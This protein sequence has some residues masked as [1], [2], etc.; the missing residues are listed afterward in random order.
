MPCGW[1]GRLLVIDDTKTWDELHRVDPG[2]PQNWWPGAPSYADAAKLMFRVMRQ[3]N[4]LPVLTALSLALLAEVYTTPAESDSAAP[5]RRVRLGYRSSPI[6]DFGIAKG[7]VRVAPQDRLAYQRR[8]D[9]S[10][11]HGQDPD[12][13]YWLYFTTITGEE[14][15][16]DVSMFT[17]NLCLYV[18]TAPY[19]SP[20]EHRVVPRAPVL[21]A[22]RAMRR[23]TPAAA[24]HTERRRVS[25]LRNKKLHKAVEHTRVSLYDCDVN[26]IRKF[27]EGLLERP[28]TDQEEELTGGWIM[29]CCVELAENLKEERWKTYP[30]SP[31]EGVHA[32]PGQMEDLLQDFEMPDLGDHRRRRRRR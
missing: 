28:L 4:V 16:L 29:Q 14:L 30:A 12:E 9:G 22:D 24:L 26:V 5:R 1:T 15:V 20:A 6:A 3:G 25:V 17:F 19:V 31:P 10:F 18:D 32:D 23:R 7:S 2:N 8:S 21:F 27:M 13:H 11:A